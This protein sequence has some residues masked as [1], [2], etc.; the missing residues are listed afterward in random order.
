MEV[1]S[2]CVEPRVHQRSSSI[3]KRSNPLWI[4]KTNLPRIT[5]SLVL[6][7]WSWRHWEPWLPTAS[8]SFSAGKEWEKWK[9]RRKWDQESNAFYLFI[10]LCIWFITAFSIHTILPPL[11]QVLIFHW[12]RLNEILEKYLELFDSC[13]LF[14][15][16]ILP[17]NTS[18]QHYL[19]WQFHWSL[20]NGICPKTAKS[21]RRLLY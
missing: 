17:Y 21:A 13:S 9:G 6:T 8:H 3:C 18:M 15:L 10:H 2:L 19:L 20:P 7:W 4:A 12:I 14:S 16:P 11:G 1:T 5:R